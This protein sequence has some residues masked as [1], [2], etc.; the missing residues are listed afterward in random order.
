M[1]DVGRVGRYGTVANPNRRT[2]RQ[3]CRPVTAHPP[4]TSL[5]E[6]VNARVLAHLE[7]SVPRLFS[8]FD[9]GAAVERAVWTVVL[10][11]GRLLLVAVLSALCAKV[12]SRE[13]GGRAVALRMDADYQLSQA[14]TFGEITVPLYA[15][16]EGGATRCPARA[17]VFPLHPKCR[18]S[19]LLLEWEARLGSHLPF[20]QAEDALDFF[21]H[22]AVRSEDTTISRHIGVVGGLLDHRWICRDPEKVAE[23]LAKR[24]TRDSRSGEPLLYV[25]T[26]AHSLRRYVD[27]SWKAEG[28]MLNGI[29][30]WCIDRKTGQTIH[31]GGEYTWGDCREVALRMG[32]LIK[33]LVPIDAAAPQMVLVVDGMPWIRDHVHPML[34]KGTT[35]ILDFYHLAQ[36]LEAYA[37][38]RFG[39]GSDGA[40]AWVRRAV[41]DLTGKRPY[42]T[43]VHDKRRGHRKRKQG[44]ADPFRTVH[45]SDHPHGAGDKFLR[46]LISAE[47]ASEALDAL[48]E[49]VAANVDRIDYSDY[50]GRGMQIGSGA[51][52]SLHR[53]ASQ[54]RLKLAGARWTAE[55]AIA[56][57]NLRLMLLAER[58]SDFWGHPDLTRTL[59]AAFAG[60]PSVDKVAA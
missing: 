31:I 28:K 3:E 18:S 38:A 33:H 8:T 44:R 58:W 7:K 55:R 29:R 32:V 34:P 19:E 53:V 27:D 59:S 30:F 39:A 43:K 51:M 56:V 2:T 5:V 36:H 22:G 60:A 16:R 52:E 45:A 37:A 14:T 13:T 12:T 15:F 42:R 25:S 35:F 57:L 10:E 48:M 49:Y 41:T 26:D 47:P 54:M 6:N 11:V 46:Q 21:S 24:A 40:R 23:I 9:S 20:R 17:E 1:I 50:R 4:I